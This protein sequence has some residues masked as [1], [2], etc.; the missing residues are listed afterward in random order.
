VEINVKHYK[1]VKSYV[2]NGDLEDKLNGCSQA[3]F[4]LKEIF[5]LETDPAGTT[6]KTTKYFL[7]IMEIDNV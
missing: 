4:N 6:G 3:G 5:L 2:S 1:I 7:A